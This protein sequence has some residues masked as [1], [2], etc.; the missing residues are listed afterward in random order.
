MYV[1]D[2]VMYMYMCVY[3]SIREYVETYNMF[4]LFFIYPLILLCCL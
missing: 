3:M 4:I 2:T 1:Y